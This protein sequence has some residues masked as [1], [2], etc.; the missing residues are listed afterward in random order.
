MVEFEKEDKEVPASLREQTQSIAHKMQDL[1]M[2]HHQLWLQFE[3][4]SEEGLGSS[5][6]LSI[7]S[8]M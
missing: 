4:R 6:P 2:D 5:R 7:V 1:R 3:E 8:G